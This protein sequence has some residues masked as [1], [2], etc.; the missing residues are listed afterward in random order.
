MGLAQT[1]FFRM[2]RLRRFGVAGLIAGCVTR[3]IAAMLP[4]FEIYLNGTDAMD[5]V[6]MNF[7]YALIDQD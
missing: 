6:T 4:P 5:T 2:S 3:V 7:S 1:S